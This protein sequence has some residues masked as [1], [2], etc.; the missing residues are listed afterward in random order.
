M[1]RVNPYSN[2]VMILHIHVV[3]LI[4]G[5]CDCSTSGTVEAR[6]L[7]YDCPP[8]PQPGEE[9]TA[10]SIVPGPYSNLLESAVVQ[11]VHPWGAFAGEGPPSAPANHG[12][13]GGVDGSGL[14]D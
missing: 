1:E 10:A 3:V 12:S 7:E 8:N 5:L 9:G 11:G 2:S 13:N 4:V 14:R 6:K